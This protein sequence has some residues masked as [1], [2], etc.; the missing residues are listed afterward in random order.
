MKNWEERK[1]PVCECLHI[2]LFCVSF[3][4]YVIY[5]RDQ[6]TVVYGPATIFVNK[7]FW[8]IWWVISATWQHKM[9]LLFVPPFQKLNF[10]IHLWT[11]V[12]L[13]KLWD[14]APYAK[15]PRRVPHMNWQIGIPTDCETSKIWQMGSSLFQP[16]L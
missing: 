11:K 12:P 14:P 16:W 2:F 1:L 5:S 8:R 10:G 13:W 9:P 15:G 4:T 3:K 6:Q 7:I